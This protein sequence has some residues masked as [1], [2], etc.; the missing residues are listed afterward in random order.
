MKK[1]K[2]TIEFNVPDDVTE[3]IGMSLK[4]NTG[5]NMV[6]ALYYIH[7]KQ[8]VRDGKHLHYN[9]N[10]CTVECVGERFPEEC[11]CESVNEVCPI[12]QVGS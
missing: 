10:M 3:F 12:H 9:H 1:M 6:R 8:R 5:K 2:F 11:L 4:L 7:K